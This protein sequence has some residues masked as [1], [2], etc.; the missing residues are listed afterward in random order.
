MEAAIRAAL[1]E[2]CRGELAHHLVA[3]KERAGIPL[4]DGDQRRVRQGQ[5]HTVR[6]ELLHPAP[7]RGC[8]T[9]LLPEDPELA[10]R[11]LVSLLARR[12][13]PV[14]ALDLTRP[15]FGIPVVRVLAPGLQIE[16]SS[17]ASDR[18]RQAI[19]EYGGGTAHHG[20]LPLL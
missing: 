9:A 16:P 19:Q 7:R 4:S 6:C 15:V 20:G 12:G 11:E 3:A 5:L 18:L 13:V 17:I 1:L 2:M 8:A 10:L 14:Y